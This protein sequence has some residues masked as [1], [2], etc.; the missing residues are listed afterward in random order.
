MDL[1][2]TGRAVDAGEAVAI[3]LVNRVVRDGDS[4]AAAEQLARELAAFPQ[5]GTREDRLSAREQHRLEERAALALEFEHGSH[6][7]LEVREGVERFRSGAGRYG[8]FGA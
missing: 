4:R 1:V 8:A 3:G 2:L 5:T 7:L 6:S